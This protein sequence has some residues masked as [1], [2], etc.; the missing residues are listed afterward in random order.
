MYTPLDTG[1]SAAPSSF[2]TVPGVIG[3]M[4][5]IAVGSSP[6]KNN[7]GFT[8]IQMQQQMQGQVCV[9]V[10]VC[11]CVRVCVYIYVCVRMRVYVC[12]CVC[13]YVHACVW[14]CVAST[15]MRMHECIY[16]CLCMLDK[17]CNNASG[18][19]KILFAKNST[20]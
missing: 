3:S 12:V 4:E 9:C 7:Y 20:P 5:G 8:G 18:V 1:P 14:V 11:V 17:L 15:C 13:V 10:C 19:L 16:R 2:T 6:A